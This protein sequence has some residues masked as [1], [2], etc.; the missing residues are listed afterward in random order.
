[1][2]TRLTG[3]DAFRTDPP[4]GLPG[5]GPEDYSRQFPGIENRKLPGALEV[6]AVRR[7]LRGK[8]FSTHDAL[9]F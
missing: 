9:H 7:T 1:M 4:G 2:I 6:D 8:T 5:V 3:F